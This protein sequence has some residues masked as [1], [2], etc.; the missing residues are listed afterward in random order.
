[1]NNSTI[2]T[3]EKVR[4][5]ANVIMEC[6]NV[7]KTIF[8]DFGASMVSVGAEDVFVGNASES[9]GQRFASL[10]TK[11]DSYTQMVESFSRQILSAS[12]NTE[13]TEQRL[14]ADADNLAG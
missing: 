6:A 14:A 7:M 12:S 9:L 11:F 1:M 8:E 2:I 13:Q 3:Y 5:D 4:D 10:K